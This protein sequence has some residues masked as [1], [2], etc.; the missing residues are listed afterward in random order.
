MGLRTLYFNMNRF[1]EQIAVAKAEGSV[2][3]WLDRIT[4]T[5]LLILDDFG[6]QPITHPVTAK[7]P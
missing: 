2:I 6:L 7:Q 3:K 1:C 5:P 4:K